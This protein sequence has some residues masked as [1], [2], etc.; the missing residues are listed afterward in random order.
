M[1]SKNCIIC[2][3]YS[4]RPFCPSCEDTAMEYFNKICEL[5]KINPR[6]TVIEIYAETSIP[7]PVIYGLKDIGWI[8]IIPA[9]GQLFVSTGDGKFLSKSS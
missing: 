5:L 2:G 7:L 6:Y 3:Y 1:A 8:E 4:S 9:E